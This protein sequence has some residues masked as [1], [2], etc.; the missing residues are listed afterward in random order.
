M[1][2]SSFYAVVALSS[3]SVIRSLQNVGFSYKLCLLV[4]PSKKLYG[5]KSGSLWCHS[6]RVLIAHQ[7]PTLVMRWKFT[8]CMGIFGISMYVTLAVYIRV[9][10]EAC[11]IEGNNDFRIKKSIGC[12]FFKTYCKNVFFV[13][14]YRLEEGAVSAPIL[15]GYN[16]KRFVTPWA[17]DI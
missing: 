2:V 14:F 3:N 8:N 11:L 17:G 7:T 13:L 1:L 5:L 15:H 16:F 6:Q 12:W 4:S 9:S 10:T